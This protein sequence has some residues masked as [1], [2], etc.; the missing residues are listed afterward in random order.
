IVGE[1][2]ERLPQA[3]LRSAARR[4]SRGAAQIVGDDRLPF[5]EQQIEGDDPGAG[6][7]ELLNRLGKEAPAERPAAE[8]GEA[9]I[10]DEDDDGFRLR[11]LRAP[12][13]EAQIERGG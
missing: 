6:A 7:I 2:R 5:R 8:L 13:A 9:R 11:W 10:V 1:L 4:G 12:Q 3:R